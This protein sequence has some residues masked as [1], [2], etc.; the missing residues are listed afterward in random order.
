MIKQLPNQIHST[1]SDPNS[2]VRNAIQ[3]GH[4]AAQSQ[5]K[6]NQSI[7]PPPL[8]RPPSE[9][10]K[11]P[12][13]HQFTVGLR[14]KLV[15]SAA[16]EAN[17]VSAL[18]ERNNKNNNNNTTTMN[19][20]IVVS[21]ANNSIGQTRYDQENP[22]DKTMHDA[23]GSAVSSDTPNW[24]HVKGV[25]V[26]TIRL[27]DQHKYN[28]E[29]TK[30]G[31]T[32]P[33][34]KKKSNNAGNPK[35][36]QA[37]MS[38]SKQMP[39]QFKIPYKR[40]R[41]VRVPP[42]A[43]EQMKLG[44]QQQSNQVPARPAHDAHDPTYYTRRAGL[45]PHEKH[46][47]RFHKDVHD[48]DTSHHKYV[49]PKEALHPDHQVSDI[50]QQSNARYFFVN[51]NKPQP[52]DRS[53]TNG[54][55]NARSDN[56]KDI[57][58]FSDN[59]PDWM[60]IPMVPVVP[61]KYRSGVGGAEVVSGANNASAWIRF[62]HD[63]PNS[64]TQHDH[65]ITVNSQAAPEW[66]HSPRRV[67]NEQGSTNTMKWKKPEPRTTQHNIDTAHGRS[68]PGEKGHN[69]FYLRH[70][71]QQRIPYNKK[72]KH[73]QDSRNKKDGTYTSIPHASVVSKYGPGHFH[74]QGV[75]IVKFQSCKSHD[76]SAGP[77]V[78]GARP[79]TADTPRSVRRN[80]PSAQ[81]GAI[82][83]DAPPHMKVPGVKVAGGPVPN[84]KPM[85]YGADRKPAMDPK[86]RIRVAK[87][88]ATG[89]R[90]KYRINPQQRHSVVLGGKPS[91]PDG[92]PIHP[93]LGPTLSLMEQENLKKGNVI[94]H[95]KRPSTSSNDGRNGVSFLGA[96]KRKYKRTGKKIVVP[97]ATHYPQNPH[98]PV[99]FW[100]RMEM[101]RKQMKQVEQ[102]RQQRQ[103]QQQQQQQQQRGGQQ[104]QQRNNS[105]KE[106][107]KR[108]P[109]TTQKA[110]R[111]NIITGASNTNAKERKIAQLR[112][113]IAR[114]EA[115]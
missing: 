4:I 74:I 16:A 62:D 54:E 23:K 68:M 48:G 34:D 82:S 94:V 97:F 28:Q 91:N 73:A 20:P 61:A 11:R 38:T 85:V 70:P 112:A 84:M 57:S 36:T 43:G 71:D 108:T 66:M 103:Q 58:A 53:T 95:P 21:T 115:T 92:T 104:Q 46:I 72:N 63:N 37:M 110:A 5:W 64:K 77:Y 30:V 67:T 114:L 8:P 109:T 31:H 33:G 86:E 102:K 25:P 47:P 14:K 60:H 50:V 29:N 12:A 45:A 79:Q 101:K 40:G 87:K 78:S 13:G 9:K 27:Q 55:R 3:V 69:Y 107:Q 105:G 24:F 22:N 113:Q 89:R 88:L 10:T 56:T 19:Q 96:G 52:N 90:P 39:P 111:V 2:A 32:H 106:N 41:T 51:P 81:R 65:D 59:C 44:S 35:S 49:V 100:D 75:P 15:P 93:S 1:G 99:P 98:A 18:L 83:F 42:S 7:P 76:P 6:R 17:Q 80:H 26:T